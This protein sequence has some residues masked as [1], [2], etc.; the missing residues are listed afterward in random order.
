MN[1]KIKKL[2]ISVAIFTVAIS[3]A[4]VKS[5]AGLQA[6]KGGTSLTY[7]RGSQIFDGTR[8]ME[9]QYG[10]LGKNMVLG[11]KYLDPSGNGIDSH[12][13]L[14]TEWGTMAFL[15]D[16]SFGIGSEIKNNKDET[17][18][19]NESGIYNLVNGKDEIT[20]A[21]VQ[22]KSAIHNSNFVNADSRYFNNYQSETS[23]IGDAYDCR[24][25]LSSGV[26]SISD[27][28]KVFLRGGSSGLFSWLSGYD[29]YLSYYAN[30]SSRAV[31]VCGEGL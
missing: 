23:I 4:P 31:A 20:A 13:I 1:I 21:T 24:G 30:R 28:A 15:A 6:N 29:D 14:S 18:T 8:K 10:T 27:N 3:V 5:R 17:S 25:W 7:T 11:D 26:S 16:S 22:G 9:T 12:M 19:G 2:L